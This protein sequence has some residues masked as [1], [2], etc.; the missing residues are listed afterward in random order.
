MIDWKLRGNGPAENGAV[1][2]EIWL[3]GQP[4][5]T[6]YLD[7]IKDSVVGGADANPAELTA[8]WRSAN[9]YYQE[10]EESEA[11]IADRAERRELDSSLAPLAAEVGADPSYRRAFNT[12]PTEFGLVELDKLIVFQKSVTGTF[13]DTLKA[14]LGPAPDPAALFR[15]CLPLGTPDTPVEARR[16]GSKRFIFR[17]DSTDFRFH[18]PAL[19]R[20]EQICDYVSFGPIT[21]VVG[22]VVGFGS[23]FL[24]VIRADRRLLL[25]NGYHR[26]CALR[27]LGIT[28]APCIIQ[29]VTSEDE[30]EVTAKSAVA[31]DPAFYFK[32]ARPPLLKDF[33]DPKIRRALRVHKHV[34][35]IEVSFEVRD[36]L[37]PE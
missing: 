10:L 34:R 2:E 4:P 33:F 19:L 7:F 14:R 25:H 3:L 12:L 22:L 13:I 9:I 35:M 32:S 37:V 21:G 15:F 30:L 18:G 24:N 11:G 5:L 27:A 26:A 36:Y 28:H 8:E 31:K 23:N 6:Q 20:P 1:D 16:M 17:S 29:T